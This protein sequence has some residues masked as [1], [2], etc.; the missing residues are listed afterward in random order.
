MSTEA[1]STSKSLR[2]GRIEK[3]NRLAGPSNG[4]AR[5]DVVNYCGVAQSV[6]PQDDR[7][8]RRSGRVTWLATAM[9]ESRRYLRCT[10]LHTKLLAL[11]QLTTLLVV[12]GPAPR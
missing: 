8:H 11:A 10:N 7:Q 5:Q 2:S 6:S 1:P 9:S 12:T 3:G 4:Y